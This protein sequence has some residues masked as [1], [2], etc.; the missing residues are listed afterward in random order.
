MDDLQVHLGMQE[1][2]TPPGNNML[3]KAGRKN[4]VDAPD[5]IYSGVAAKTRI[6]LRL[7]HSTVRLSVRSSQV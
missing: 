4:I 7:P 5:G 6:I 3:H 2:A 1:L